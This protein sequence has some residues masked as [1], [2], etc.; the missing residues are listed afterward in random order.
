MLLPC[1]PITQVIN[2][3]LL[4][5]IQVVVDEDTRKFSFLNTK[6]IISIIRIHSIIGTEYMSFGT[7][8]FCIL[9][10]L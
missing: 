7:A 4:W 5:L 8:L 10:E 9:F 1:Q 6:R 3:F 2:V